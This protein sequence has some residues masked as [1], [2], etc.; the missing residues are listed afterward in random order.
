MP[1]NLISKISRWQKFDSQTTARLRER[2][3]WQVTSEY[4]EPITG[5]ELLSVGLHT[6]WVQLPVTVRNS[7]SVPAWI[8]VTAQL[9]PSCLWLFQ[10]LLLLSLSLI[11]RHLLRI[12]S[13]KK[14]N[15]WYAASFY[16]SADQSLIGP[17][18]VF[19]KLTFREIYS[20]DSISVICQQDREEGSAMP[21]LNS[22]YLTIFVFCFVFS[23]TVVKYPMPTVVWQLIS[24]WGFCACVK[25]V[26]EFW[27]ES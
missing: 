2:F 4:W 3:Q 23:P 17:Y 10:L 22:A 20:L 25:V 27:E 18:K 13:W 1:L 6:V 7:H 11:N 9:D 21:E 8:P 24:I 15:F 14:K 16:T 5:A 26:L 12:C 19:S